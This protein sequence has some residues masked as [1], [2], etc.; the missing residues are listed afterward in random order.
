M[1]QCPCK[2]P[3]LQVLRSADAWPRTPQA[4]A[5]WETALPDSKGHLQTLPSFVRGRFV[6][7][8]LSGLGVDPRHMHMWLCFF[9]GAFEGK[10]CVPGA[11]K[12]LEAADTDDTTR[13]QAAPIPPSASGVVVLGPVPY[14]N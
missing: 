9:G 11:L 14:H 13:K 8:F 7:H 6:F 10:D 5:W 4:A 12:W 2:V 1:R 3:R